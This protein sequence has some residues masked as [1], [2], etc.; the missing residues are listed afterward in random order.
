MGVGLLAELS[1]LSGVVVLV[2][3]QELFGFVR[4]SD[5]VLGDGVVECSFLTDLRF[6]FKPIL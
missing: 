3:G 5:S 1:D 6:A 2:S 4:I